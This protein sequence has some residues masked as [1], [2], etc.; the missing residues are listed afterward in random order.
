M[1]LTYRPFRAGDLGALAHLTALTM[2][3]DP[4]NESRL[5]ANVL[6]EPNFRPEGLTVAADADAGPV[7]FLYATA[8]G[9][10]G[11]LTIGSVHPDF[12]RQGIGT[13]L[14]DAA[15]SH[16][17]TRG[18]VAVTV[19]GYPAAYFTPGLDTGTYPQTQRLL[20]K[21]GFERQY[22]AAAMHCDLDSY[23]GDPAAPDLIKRRESEGYTFGPARLD[24]LPEAIA[25]ASAT[26]APDWGTVIRDSQ[27]RF[28]R[29]GARVLLARKPDGAIAGFATYGAYEDAL[30]RFGPFGV[31]PDLRGTGL[32]RIL[33]H[34]TLRAM[35]AEG[36][37]GAWFLWTGEDSP[38]GHLYRSA[39]FDV[40]RRFDVMRADLTTD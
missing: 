26:L 21:H 34:L 8:E 33:L 10:Q 20:A 9:D 12:Q 3:R 2:P 25:F 14:L 22:T 40:V 23:A 39:A 17:R 4:V 37:H 19:S 28:R 31:D 7:G 6:L 18:A 29:D 11:Y 13:A 38:A 27:L 15:T 1:S 16:L 24:D 36:A 32:G 35:R 5:A 30:E